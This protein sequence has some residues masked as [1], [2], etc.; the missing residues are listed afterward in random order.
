MPCIADLST[1]F[2]VAGLYGKPVIRASLASL[3]PRTVRANPV[4]EALSCFALA[5]RRQIQNRA[6]LPGY[7]PSPLQKE[8]G[9]DLVD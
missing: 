3:F 6:W 8:G 1:L 5:D 4:N 9:R 2:A 7:L